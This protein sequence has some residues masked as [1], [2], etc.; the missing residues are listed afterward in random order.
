M[1]ERYRFAAGQY[2]TLRATIDG[3]DAR[4]AYSICAGEDDAALRVAIKRVPDGT[5]ST[6]AHATLVAGAALAVAPPQGRFVRPAGARDAGTYLGFA[7][8][9]GIT[10]L[11]SILKTTLAR[12]AQSRFTLVY[13]NRATSSTM[14]REELQGLKD[15]YLARLTLVF[16]M[17]REAQD[18]ELFSG[19]IDRARCDA[20][21][22]R[23][24]DTTALHTAYVCGPGAMA[25]DVTA[26]L[27][28]RGVAPERVRRERFASPQDGREPRVGRGTVAAG[29]DD[30]AATARFEG[31]ERAFAIARGTETV[32]DAALRAGIDVP[33]A[34]KGGVCATCRAVLVRGEV[35]M[36]VNY[37]LEEY[38]VRRGLI[39]ACQS[40][41]ASDSIAIDV[42]RAAQF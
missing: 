3:A 28:A 12:E 4:R 6:W 34:C 13:G 14:F 30:I 7:A 36:D 9:S 29:T 26:A 16:V 32:L 40:Y 18:A 15:R 38:E 24:I 1:R 5:F 33:Y 10:P 8:G 17:S 19:R 39:L 37:A 22:E 35:D 42:D 27:V 20:L 11:L 21:L 23:W 2:V 31:R 41:P 25:D